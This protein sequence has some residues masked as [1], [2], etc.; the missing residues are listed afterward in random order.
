[1]RWFYIMA[2]FGIFSLFVFF[3]ILTQTRPDISSFQSGYLAFV[4]V[5]FFFSQI[6]LFLL[7]VA[8]LCTFREEEETVTV[9]KPVSL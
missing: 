9:Y 2:E 4:W 7:I 6:D 5:C 1:M 8:L 3:Y